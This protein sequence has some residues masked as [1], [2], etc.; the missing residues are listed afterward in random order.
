[1]FGELTVKWGRRTNKYQ[2]KIQLENVILVAYIMYFWKL[3]GEVTSR[4]FRVIQ[5]DMVKKLFMENWP[6]SK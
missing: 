3:R 4:R 6:K 2:F 5:G 1:M